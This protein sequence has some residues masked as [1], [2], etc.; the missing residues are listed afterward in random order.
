MPINRWTPTTSKIDRVRRVRLVDRVEYRQVP[1][2]EQGLRQ[3]SA[4]W[5]DPAVHGLEEARGLDDPELIAIRQGDGSAR[6]IEEIHGATH[7][8]QE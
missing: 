5:D 1:V 3:A 4:R 7:Q 8:E 2:P 6:R